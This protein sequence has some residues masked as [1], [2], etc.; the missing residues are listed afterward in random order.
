MEVV[1]ADSLPRDA[2]QTDTGS[3]P[4]P[5]PAGQQA[6][7]WELARQP[8]HS[9]VFLAPM[10]V[11]VELLKWSSSSPGERPVAIGVESW[12]QSLLSNAGIH[13][14]CLLP[15]TLFLLLIGWHLVGRYRTGIRPSVLCGMAFE[16][17]MY[18]C[19]LVVIGQMQDLFFQHIVYRGP[20]AIDGE[21]GVDFLSR[22]V[23]FVA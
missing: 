21:F 3:P 8:L 23:T 11:G 13:I 12:I 14:P 7:Y 9:L 5:D 2:I 6:S 4:S 17:L 20:L 22:I 16:S 18:A 1:R 15:A 10:V 19:L